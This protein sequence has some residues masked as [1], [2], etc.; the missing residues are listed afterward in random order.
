MDSQDL[1]AFIAIYESKNIAQASEKLYISPQGLGKML[2]RMEYELGVDLFERSVSGSNP[3][4]YGDLLYR[5]ARKIISMLDNIAKGIDIEANETATICLPMTN[6]IWEVLPHSFI[7]EFEELASVKV[8]EFTATDFAIESYLQKKEAE[9]G[10]VSGPYDASKFKGIHLTSRKHILVMNKGN[11]L[12]N[13]DRIS[14]SDLNKKHIALV[15]RMDNVYKNLMNRFI[16]N[17]V[18]PIIDLESSQMREIIN[19]AR[20][21]PDCISISVDTSVD[22]NELGDLVVKYFEDESL[23]WDT[24]IVFLSSTN[25]SYFSELFI[26]YAQK[27]LNEHHKRV[28]AF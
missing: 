11:P 17:N 12:A 22:P 5:K 4:I 10:V 13:K 16:M 24:Y 21:S 19:N 7:D 27:W 14:Y 25:L 1:K 26:S 8:D 3:T 23:T 28:I 15:T 2:K 20:N 6:G 18:H 9:I